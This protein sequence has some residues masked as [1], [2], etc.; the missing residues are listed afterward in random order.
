MRGIVTADLDLPTDQIP[1]LMYKFRSTMTGKQKHEGFMKAD[2]FVNAESIELRWR[3]S[4]F[5]PSMQFDFGPPSQVIVS[6]QRQVLYMAV[7]IAGAGQSATVKMNPG[8]AASFETAVAAGRTVGSSPIHTTSCRSVPLTWCTV[9]TTR[10]PFRR[11][12]SVRC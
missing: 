11:A 2:V 5:G 7:A 1:C 4:R 9:T 6:V 8:C 12:S 3:P 10:A